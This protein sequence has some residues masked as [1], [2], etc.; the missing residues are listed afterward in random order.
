MIKLGDSVQVIK[1][2]GLNLSSIVIGEVVSYQQK[3]YGIR[4]QNKTYYCYE[5][6]I[7]KVEKP[8]Q[9]EHYV[10]FLSYTFKD[11]KDSQCFG[12]GEVDFKRPLITQEDFRIV[13]GMMKNSIQKI[14]NDKISTLVILNFQL[15][16][17]FKD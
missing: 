3:K 4:T 7:K 1:C 11:S 12:N 5:N 6:E 2:N 16:K 15:L 10:Y 9:E 8:K 13:E 14:I 17:H